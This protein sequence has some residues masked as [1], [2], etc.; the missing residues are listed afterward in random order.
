MRI[1]ANRREPTIGNLEWFLNEGFLKNIQDE[2]IQS[3]IQSAHDLLT[4]HLRAEWEHYN[5]MRNVARDEAYA[6]VRRLS[7]GGAK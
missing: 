1:P 4:E 2:L 5:Q 3:A 6:A 7:K